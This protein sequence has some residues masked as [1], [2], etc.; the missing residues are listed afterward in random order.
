MKLWICPEDMVRYENIVVSDLFN[1]LHE[2]MNG[3]KIGADLGL[4]KDSADFHNDGSLM[5]SLPLTIWRPDVGRSAAGPLRSL[6]TPVLDGVAKLQEARCLCMRLE[7][8]LVFIH[9]VEPD[10]VHIVGILNDIEP[11][12]TWLVAHGTLGVLCHSGD[13]LV[14]EPWLNLDRC[15]DDV[16][17]AS[18]AYFIIDDLMRRTQLASW[19]APPLVSQPPVATAADKDM[20]AIKRW[21][22]M[23]P[24]DSATVALDPQRRKRNFSS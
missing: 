3:S 18:S 19:Y 12:A 9:F 22:L 23:R 4:R 20:P 5:R 15:N 21:W 7:R 24:P 11:E 17:N 14:L 1:G 6:S 8:R 2:G 16:H 10:A 13:E